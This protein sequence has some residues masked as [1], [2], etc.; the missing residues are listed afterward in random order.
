MRDSSTSAGKVA[1]LIIPKL[2]AYSARNFTCPYDGL[3]SVQNM[4]I[5]MGIFD[6]VFIPAGSYMVNN[7]R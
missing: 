7:E 6:D 5:N 2:Q 1:N 4:P 3:F